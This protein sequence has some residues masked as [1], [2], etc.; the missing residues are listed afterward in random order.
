MP[1]IELAH[2]LSTAAAIARGAGAILQ[3]AGSDRAADF[4]L[5]EIDLVTEYD[6]RSEAFIV[7][8]LR[9]A[10]PDHA[11]RAEEGSRANS[12]AE[13]EWVVDPLDG[14]TNFAHHLPIYSVVLALLHRGD[15]L[16]GVIFDPTR[17]EMFTAAKDEGAFLNGKPLRVSATR[18]LSRALLVT[19]FPYNIRT[20]PDNNIARFNHFA[21]RARAVRRLGSAALDLAYVA[22]GRLDGYWE[23]WL[24]P[25]DVAAGTL[26][27]R[28]AGG[29]VT[30]FDDVPV[31]VPNIGLVASNG[32]I[33]SEMLT[34]IR[35]GENAPKP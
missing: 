15:P 29:R 28:E 30:N 23:S 1:S 22:A 7:A 31:P 3:E 2:A 9:E 4:K 19:G 16:I 10:F 25:W 11:L 34:V 35:E 17:D 13:Y 27:V 33:H 5:N 6:R 24:S 12:G 18:P 32:L 14:T 21:L 20:N 26:M 8:A